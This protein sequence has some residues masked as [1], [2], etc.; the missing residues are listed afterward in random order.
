[1]QRLIRGF[2]ALA[3]DTTPC[4]QPLPIAHAHALMVLGARGALSQRELGAELRIDKSNIARLCAK[5]VEAGHVEQRASE[6]DGRS[7]IVSL[8]AA[9]QRLAREVDAAS[10]ARFAAV[11]A[12][13]PAERRGPLLEGLEQLVAAVESLPSHPAGE[14]EK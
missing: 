7:R 1:M 6:R 13:L 11:L 10:H 14:D 5:M 2:G 4:G 8:T 12:A 9:G 3:A